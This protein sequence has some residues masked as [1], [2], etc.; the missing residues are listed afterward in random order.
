MKR[1][2][3]MNLSPAWV[4]ILEAEGWEADAALREILRQIGV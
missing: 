3:D 1:L 4:D 2:L